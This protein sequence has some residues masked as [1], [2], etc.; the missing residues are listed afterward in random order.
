MSL[1]YPLTLFKAD[2]DPPNA[3]EAKFH[4]HC[5]QDTPIRSADLWA[6]A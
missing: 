6:G 4:L 3:P 2:S 1:G 5:V